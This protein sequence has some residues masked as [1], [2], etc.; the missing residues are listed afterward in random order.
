MYLGLSYCIKQSVITNELTLR[1]LTGHPV[2][3]VT[4]A[5]FFIG[6]ASLALIAKNVFEQFGAEKKISFSGL[7]TIAGDQHDSVT[8]AFTAAQQDQ[9]PTIA[10]ANSDS[11]TDVEADESTNA[12]EL[13][14]RLLAL[15]AWMHDHYLYQR[16][17]NSLESIER[18]NS[19]A[20]AEEEL[21]Y[22]ADLDLDQQQQRYS[23]VRILIWATPMLGFLGT[24][25]GIS[26]ALGGI[27]VG[28][29]NDFQQ[30]MN[31]LRGS[32]YV[33]FDTTAL[34]LTLSMLMMFGQFLIERFETQLLLL[35]DH[36]AKFEIAS[37]FDLTQTTSASAEQL[38]ANILQAS[39][40]SVERQTEIWTKSVR[41]AEKAWAASLTQVNEQVQSNLSQSL[42]E[43][44]ANLA[45]YLGEAIGRADDAM[46][47]RWQQWQVTL[48]DN[49]RRLDEHQQRLCEQTQFIEGIAKQNNQAD[50]FA[51]VI[52]Q[53]EQAIVAT[54][55]LQNSMA[56]LSSVIKGLEV[57]KTQSN[58]LQHES[59]K[60][61]LDIA[62]QQGLAGV[63]GNTLEEVSATENVACEGASCTSA[64]VDSQTSASDTERSD[65][66]FV[67]PGTN[68]AAKRKTAVKP[69]NQVEDAPQIF[70]FADYVSP[71]PALA[72]TQTDAAK[73][74]STQTRVREAVVPFA[75]LK[76]IKG[77]S[78]KQES[79]A[80]AA[81]ASS[82]VTPVKRSTTPRNSKVAGANLTI[83][84]SSPT[85]N[86]AT[87][88]LPNLGSMTTAG[89]N[90]MPSRRSAKRAA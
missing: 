76:P 38:T 37:Q 71:K 5:M 26:Q 50:H 14:E 81:I 90:Q 58:N 80:S 68:E 83:S 35:V 41:A 85:N 70:R 17:T 47:H 29:D 6:I 9:L 74:A 45:H 1:Y 16:L 43:N 34:A 23:L 22:L 36:R 30:M 49:A 52:E 46:S 88:E 63:A 18:S 3:E 44:V 89:T 33:A 12:S 20:Q 13:I 32:L 53:N 25:L 60:Q 77:V 24:V 82:S 15:P 67:L 51:P 2:S 56:E 21:K 11:S 61:L 55:N 39:R 65:V 78:A 48:S 27:S 64:E 54:R 62:G 59:L 86:Y 40:E 57:A 19:P 7:A 66:Q 87:V 84:P 79:A 69:T 73:A 42:D 10:A 72:A 31:G 28:P 75:T 8:D 4:V